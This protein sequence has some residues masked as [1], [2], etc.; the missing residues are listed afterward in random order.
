MPYKVRQDKHGHRR[1]YKVKHLKRC[2]KY[3]KKP[4][5]KVYR[6]KA[7]AHKVAVRKTGRRKIGRK[8]SC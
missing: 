3:A 8:C 2:G 5:R 1:V 7:A 4:G 6:T